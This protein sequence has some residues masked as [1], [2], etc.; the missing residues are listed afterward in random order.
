MR[1]IIIKIGQWIIDSMNLF[2]YLIFS[3]SI[4][5]PSLELEYPY[6]STCKHLPDVDEQITGVYS[7]ISGSEGNSV[8]QP[9]YLNVTKSKKQQLSLE[10]KKIPPH[11]TNV[12]ESVNACLDQESLSEEYDPVYAEPDLSKKRKSH[13]PLLSTTE[14][15]NESPP[16][17]PPRAEVL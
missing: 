10:E 9:E 11:P 12:S 2:P 6:Y 7:V 17:I 5:Q 14:S 8:E 1:I 16:P 3:C 4:P 15:I 13:S